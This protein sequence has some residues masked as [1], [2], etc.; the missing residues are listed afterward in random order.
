MPG[1]NDMI[2]GTM[3][4]MGMP[5]GANMPGGNLPLQGQVPQQG[6]QKTLPPEAEAKFQQALS[7]DSGA[8]ANFIMMV[9][10]Q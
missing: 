4:G 5:Q 9:V 3:T 1:L 6:P 8:M 10:N 2:D 7:G